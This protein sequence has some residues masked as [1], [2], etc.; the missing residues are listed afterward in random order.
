MTSIL[1]SIYPFAISKRGDSCTRKIIPINTIMHV[2]ELASI[3]YLQLIRFC[4]S[5]NNT[6]NKQPHI[7]PKDTNK[8]TISSTLPLYFNIVI[9]LN[10]ALVSG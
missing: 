3:I 6:A 9:S 7:F 2:R 1:L 4:S 5:E 8:L 10:M